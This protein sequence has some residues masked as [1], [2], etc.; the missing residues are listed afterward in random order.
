MDIFETFAPDPPLPR[1]EFFPVHAEWRGCV[2]L[3][4]GQRALAVKLE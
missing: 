2:S 4:R 1:H 3:C